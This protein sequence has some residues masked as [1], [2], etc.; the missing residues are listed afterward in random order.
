[1]KELSFYNIILKTKRFSEVQ[2]YSQKCPMA[3]VFF[4][5]WS[6]NSPDLNSIEPLWNLDCHVCFV[7][8]FHHLSPSSFLMYC[9]HRDFRQILRPSSILL[10]PLLPPCLDIG[11][12]SRKRYSKY[13]M[14]VNVSQQYY[15]LYSRYALRSIVLSKKIINNY[16]KNNQ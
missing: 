13:Q 1:M 11:C 16:K 5:L 6:S 14:A 12:S 10:S 9:S 4:F 7:N 2:V 15:T 3:F 8:P